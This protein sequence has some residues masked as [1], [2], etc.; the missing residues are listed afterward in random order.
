[1]FRRE[2]FWRAPCHF[3]VLAFVH[4]PSVR[5]IAFSLHLQ[6]R[7]L[8][9][10]AVHRGG[11][12]WRVIWPVYRRIPFSHGALHS[13]PVTAKLYYLFSLYMTL[14]KNRWNFQEASL[15]IRHVSKRMFDVEISYLILQTTTRW[16]HVYGC[17]E[18]SGKCIACVYA[19][20]VSCTLSCYRR[21]VDLDPYLRWSQSQESMLQ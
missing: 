14:D 4:R 12:F 9:S 11:A 1:M 6:Q 3:S 18:H 5:R 20:V 8:L 16:L 13:F 21:N 2:A 17:P 19:E 7:G 10:F 15:Y